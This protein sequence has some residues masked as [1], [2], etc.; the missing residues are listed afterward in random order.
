[1]CILPVPLGLPIRTRTKYM[2]LASSPRVPSSC[3]SWE[4][5]CGECIVRLMSFTTCW[6]YK[7]L[8]C[9]LTSSDL[10]RTNASG[11]REEQT[12]CFWSSELKNRTF[13]ITILKDFVW[14]NEQSAEPKLSVSQSAFL[15]TQAF[16]NLMWNTT[17]MPRKET[18]KAKLDFQFC[19]REIWFSN[20][21][22]YICFSSSN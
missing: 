16:C 4:N 3:S 10:K 1:M 11:G 20:I 2:G 15:F 19:N 7:A 6:M 9:C 17:E 22:Y 18:R 14:T 12:Q 5:R 13:N 8:L 21:G